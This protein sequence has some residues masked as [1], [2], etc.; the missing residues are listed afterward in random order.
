[1]GKSCFAYFRLHIHIIRNIISHAINFKGK[2]AAQMNVT[3]MR[4]VNAEN[5]K[6]HPAAELNDYDRKILERYAGK[7]TNFIESPTS[8]TEITDETIGDKR[9]DAKK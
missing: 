8:R 9:C 2:E 4:I 5:G 1:M 3:D 6:K 7:Y